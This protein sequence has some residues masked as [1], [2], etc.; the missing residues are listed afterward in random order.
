VS[1]DVIEARKRRLS[2][3]AREVY[4]ELESFAHYASRGGD[5]EKAQ[6]HAVSLLEGLSASDREAVL[7]ILDAR[8][9]EQQHEA[10][11]ALRE[12]EEM[13]RA[14]ELMRRAQDLDRAE[15]KPGNKDRTFGEAVERLR[16]AG[17]LSEED[18]RFIEQVED[19]VVEAPVIEKIEHEQARIHVHRDDRFEDLPLAVQEDLRISWWLDDHY[20]KSMRVA[21]AAV[22]AYT[23]SLNKAASLLAAS[24]FEVPPGYFSEDEEDELWGDEG[25]GDE[26]AQL[27]LWVEREQV[28][29]R[30]VVNTEAFRVATKKPGT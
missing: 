25:W 8:K 22:L 2:P 27:K 5:A 16:E 15:G 12:G 14:L 23:G 28:A 4:E 19:K 21:A 17:Q 10:E 20:V 24:G 18:E 9:A 6:E 3:Q 29:I 30:G 26:E 1:N 7:K 13:T 11:E